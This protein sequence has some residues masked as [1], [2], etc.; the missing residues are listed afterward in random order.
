MCNYLARPQSIPV[1][2][3]FKYKTTFAQACNAE[4]E[5]TPS[6]VFS[7]PLQ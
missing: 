6:A 5:E 7:L 4:E 3:F 2:E 1:E